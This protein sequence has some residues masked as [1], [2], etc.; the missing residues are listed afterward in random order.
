MNSANFSDEL[1]PEFTPEDLTPDRELQPLLKQLKL[2]PPEGY[3]ETF[4]QELQPQLEPVPPR[5]PWGLRLI[6]RL[7]NPPVLTAAAALL[8]IM[9]W[10]P[11]SLQHTHTQQQAALPTSEEQLTKSLPEGG[12][13]AARRDLLLEKD[14]STQQTPPAPLLLGAGRPVY[15]AGGGNPATETPAEPTETLPLQQAELQLEVP[16]LA[17]T[18]RH[19]EQ[20]ARRQGGYSLNSE[21]SHPEKGSASARI[22]LKVPAHQLQT[23]L[24]QIEQ[25]G[26]LRHKRMT[27]EDRRI[28]SNTWDPT[29]HQTAQKSDDKPQWFSTV[30]LQLLQKKA[31]G[32]WAQ[33]DI[34]DLLTTRLNQ[35]LRE[36]LGLLLNLF[37]LLP[38]LLIYS[39]CAWILWKLL[40]F[41]L[42]TRMQLFSSQT[43]ATAY[44]LGLLF[45][46]LL[47]GEQA[48]FKVTLLVS[49]L[50][51]VASG[52]QHLQ[53]LR[54]K[55]SSEPPAQD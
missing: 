36:T 54:A 38:A 46:P 28:Q 25:A 11:M 45:F 19:I 15:Q 55:N 6:H 8:I 30:E 9:L 50:I 24:T 53:R 35:T 4:W 23:L 33:N 41:G 2:T 3:F 37:S 20:L 49:G 17:N 27:N 14:T 32:F 18:L 16:E 10:L 7:K 29:P 22:S 51:G 26:V 43:L 44:L 47:V 12:Q 40:S 1:P 34:T 13:I 31:S 39:G 48:L 5:L 21:L 42:V 52:M